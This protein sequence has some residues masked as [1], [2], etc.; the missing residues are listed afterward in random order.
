MLIRLAFGASV[1]WA[2]PL[3]AFG[4]I[5]VPGNDVRAPDLWFAG[6]LFFAWL[7]PTTCVLLAAL[8]IGWAWDSGTALPP[9][10]R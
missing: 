9:R 5:T 8:F 7:I 10:R 2:N 3:F 1:I 6:F 4:V